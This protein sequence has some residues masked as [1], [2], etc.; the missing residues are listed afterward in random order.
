MGSAGAIAEECA[1][2]PHPRARHVILR[3]ITVA[4]K[5]GSS[6]KRTVSLSVAVVSFVDTEVKVASER[7]PH[8][9]V[10]LDTLEYTEL[11]PTNSRE[12]LEQWS[13]ELESLDLYSLMHM[14]RAI[15]HFH[16]E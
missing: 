12:S 4:V 9:G 15:P 14:L 5:P 1:E 13:R 3:G 2:Q 6:P 11:V 8:L 7:R 16:M 10:R